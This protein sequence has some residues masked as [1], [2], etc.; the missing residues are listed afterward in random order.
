MKFSL[1][2]P[3]QVWF[4][5]LGVVLLIA[6]GW[7]ATKTGPLAPI[8]VT[9]TAVERGDVSPS[10]FGIGTVEAQRAYL[11]GPT[12]SGRVMRVMVDVG[13]KVEAGQLLAEMEPVDLDARLVSAAAAAARAASAVATAQAQLQDAKSRQQWAASEAHR[14]VDLGR[15][16]FVSP[17]VVDG[18]LQQQQSADAQLAAAEST[19]ASARQDLDRVSADREAVKRQRS[20]IRLLAPAGGVV[21]SRDVEPGSTV[22]AGQAVLKLMDPASLWVKVRLDQGRSSGLGAGL[23]AE[24]TLRSRPGESLAGKVARVEPASDSV[25]EERIAQIMLDI[26]PVGMTTGEMAEVTLHLPRVRDALLIPNAALRQRGAQ[27]GVWLQDNGQPRFAPVKPGAEDLDGRVQIV[28]GLTA[29]DV[30]IVHSERNLD[31]SSRI[32]VV[33]SLSGKAQ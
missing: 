18:K 5:A 19:L 24:V 23:L 29:G 4:A 27:T 3:R 11:I 26:L 10:L 2:L 30:V 1:H 32:K 8:R 12:S 31:E 9:V 20:N 17:S 7:V 33:S 28:E 21:T 13:D 25:T 15:K 22:V 14:Y 6:L 16:G